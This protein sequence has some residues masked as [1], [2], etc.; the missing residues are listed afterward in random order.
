MGQNGL[1]ISG[2]SA[3]RR[4]FAAEYVRN[5]FRGAAAAIKAGYSR[6]SARSI[7]SELLT[8][9][10]VA[11]RVKELT[12][13]AL[14]RAE[15]GAQETIAQLSRIARADIRGLV[16]DEGNLVPIQDL[17]DD[18]ARAV[19]KVTVNKT[20]H[21]KGGAVTETETTQLDLEGRVPALQILARYHRLVSD[22]PPAPPAAAVGA[23]LTVQDR[24]ELA[25]RIA[26]ALTKVDA[27]TLEPR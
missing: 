8:F 5:G 2:S 1:S 7:A 24:I 17:D 9:P 19:R 26:F 27:E 21:T 18:I 10:D 16:D 3:R 12:E 15:M 23:N 13:A 14:S 4:R 22:E 20:V 6:A 11:Q 25:R